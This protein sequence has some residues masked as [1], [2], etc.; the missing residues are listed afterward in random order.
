VGGYECSIFG[1]FSAGLGYLEQGSLNDAAAAMEDAARR[2][3]SSK[4][5]SEW[6][7]NRI[8]SGLAM[9]RARLGDPSAVQQMEES[10]T[11]T[12]AFDDDYMAAQLSRALGESYT[13]MGD[14]ERA[15]HHLDS[16]L[17][18]YRRN[19]MRP[20][21]PRILASIA[22]LREREGESAEATEAREEAAR[23][24]AELAG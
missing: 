19:G 5:G 4:L 9:A 1:Q 7:K 22:E 6:L 18:Y 21:L 14:F 15:R 10:L 23:V 24:T 17:D 2:A 16:A 20:Y 11:R 13:Q 3:E 8:H 12:R